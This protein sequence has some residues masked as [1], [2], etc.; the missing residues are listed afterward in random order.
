M[1]PISPWTRAISFSSRAFSAAKSMMP[2]SGKREGRAADNDL[3][4]GVRGALRALDHLDAREA[5]ERR[6]VA[7]DPL[8]QFR[9]SAD[10]DERGLGGRR[11][12]HLGAH[13]ADGAD[14]RNQPVDLG[15]GRVVGEIG[16]RPAAQRQH[17]LFAAS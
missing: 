3:R 4:R 15:V 1:R 14:E 8:R 10:D 16:R 17:L 7:L 2:A 9:V 6:C 13:R 11:N 5:L 12:I